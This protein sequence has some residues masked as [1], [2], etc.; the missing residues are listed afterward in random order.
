M[1]EGVPLS[2]APTGCDGAGIDRAPLCVLQTAGGQ[3]RAGGA[4]H[5]TASAPM[6]CRRLTLAVCQGSACRFCPALWNPINS[7][8][9]RHSR[10]LGPPALS[11]GVAVLCCQLAVAA[12]L[13][14]ELKCEAHILWQDVGRGGKVWCKRGGQCG[15]Q[16]VQLRWRRSCGQ[17]ANVHVPVARLRLHQAPPI[18][19]HHEFGEA[20]ARRHLL[21]PPPT[22]GQTQNPP[23]LRLGWRPQ[24]VG[25]T[26]RKANRVCRSVECG[27]AAHR[28]HPG[29]TLT[30]P[31]WPACSPGRPLAAAGH[32]TACPPSPPPRSAGSQACRQGA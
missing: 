5:S 31:A 29:N 21:L 16:W 4:R 25:A 32:R 17:L 13:T 7:T 27:W 26:S 10:L 2:C 22:R 24:C 12:T 8:S 6:L 15:R 18:E 11:A 23:R 20:A 28:E 9:S 19:L 14:R 1:R 3:L 30:C